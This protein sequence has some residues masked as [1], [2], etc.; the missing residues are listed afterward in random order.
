MN[1]SNQRARG[2]AI[3]PKCG[4]A[5]KLYLIVPRVDA[6]PELRAFRCSPC[7]EAL[8]YAEPKSD[9]IRLD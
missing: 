7:G 8:T 4:I 9:P 6:M 2:S 1:D 3:C 5:M